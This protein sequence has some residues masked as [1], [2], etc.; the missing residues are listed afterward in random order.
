MYAEKNRHSVVGSG[1]HLGGGDGWPHPLG[2]LAIK[3]QNGQRGLAA[4]RDQRGVRPMLA[5]RMQKK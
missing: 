3:K 1:T 2:E 5:N 4:M